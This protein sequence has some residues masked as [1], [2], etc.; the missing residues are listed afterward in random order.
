MK[1]YSAKPNDVERKWYLVDAD[2]KNLGRTASK[3]AQI[4]RGKNKPEYTPSMDVGDF[5]V[6]I[7]AE[8]IQVTGNKENQKTYYRHSGFPG[9]IKNATLAEMRSR[10][11][12]RILIS[13]VKGMLPS[14]K[15]GDKLLTKLKV[16]VGSE[17]KYQAQKPELIEV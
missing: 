3:I 5:V 8:K 17:H 15:I 13:A 1:T 9:G 12:E 14:N 2:G 16:C 6:V 7:N 11:P 10:H 4:L